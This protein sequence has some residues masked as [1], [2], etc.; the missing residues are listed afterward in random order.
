MA[1]QRQVPFQ[2]KQ[3]S[4]LRS[5]LLSPSMTW[6]PSRCS[7]QR[8]D[9]GTRLCFRKLGQIHWGGTI[10]YH[11]SL[12]DAVEALRREL[13]ELAITMHCSSSRSAGVG[14]PADS[15]DVGRLFRGDVDH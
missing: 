8:Q 13:T 1:R 14:E 9:P 3:G 15:D 6:P 4:R 10:H 7:F 2:S 12:T 11:H 5:S